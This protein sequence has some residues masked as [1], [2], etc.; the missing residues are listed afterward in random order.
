[1]EKSFFKKFLRKISSLKCCL[2]KKRMMV[3]VTSGKVI[4]LYTLF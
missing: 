2:S 3:F 1:M 4:I